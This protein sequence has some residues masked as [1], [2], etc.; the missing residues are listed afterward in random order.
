LTATGRAEGGSQLQRLLEGGEF[1]VTAEVGPPRGSD[2]AVIRRKARLVGGHVD[3]AN[4]TDNQTSIVRMSS[5]A[6]C[7][8]LMEQ[9]VE[10]VMQMVCRDRN[11]I[12]IQSDLLGACALGVRNLL[13]L[14]GDHQCFGNQPAAK[15][16]FDLD[17]LQLLDA[18]R[19]MRD[20]GRLMGGDAVK[21]P[22]PLFLGAASN[23]FGDPADFRVVRLEKKIAAGAQFIQ[24]QCVFDMERFRRFMQQ[25]GDRGLLERVHLLAGLTP[26]KSLRMARYMAGKVSGIEIPGAILRRMEQTPKKRRAAEGIRLCVEQ[27]QQL[28]EIPGVRGVHLM[29][30]EWEQRVPEIVEA[31]GLH[32]RPRP[33]PRRRAPGLAREPNTRG[34]ERRRAEQ[35]EQRS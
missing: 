24:T 21:G 2:A 32:P 25:A 30:I 15:N 1:V 7:R 16:V 14:T 23:P 19:R 20:E 8:L 17:S 33:G 27:L 10:P 31:A 34:G 28:R 35:P 29:A 18:A 22:V 12:A 26:L 11:R 3:A 13:C 5:V 6:A 4:V 9:G